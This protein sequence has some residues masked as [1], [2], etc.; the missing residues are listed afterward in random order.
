MYDEA[1]SK[2]KK[3]DSFFATEAIGSSAKILVYIFL[4]VAYCQKCHLYFREELCGDQTFRVGK[5]LCSEIY[6]KLKLGYWHSSCAIS[7]LWKD[8]AFPVSYSLE[9]R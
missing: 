9:H 2:I 3:R 5:K 6:A 7:S 8:G 4:N 1:R